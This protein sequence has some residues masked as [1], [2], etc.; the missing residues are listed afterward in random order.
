MV[1]SLL[2]AAGVDKGD[3]APFLQL[4]TMFPGHRQ[5]VQS[6]CQFQGWNS[7]EVTGGF[8]GFSRNEQIWQ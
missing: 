8:N 3:L 5:L 6:R 1:A 4:G 2:E 7:V